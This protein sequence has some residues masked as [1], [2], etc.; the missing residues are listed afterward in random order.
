MKSDMKSNRWGRSQVA[1][2]GAKEERSGRG[3]GYRLVVCFT[4]LKR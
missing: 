3:R 1:G 2:E 4:K